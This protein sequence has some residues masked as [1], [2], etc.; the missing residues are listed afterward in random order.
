M[1]KGNTRPAENKELKLI[2]Q[3]A[4]GCIFHPGI[5]CRGKKENVRYITKIQKN[6]ENMKREVDMAKWITRL[7]RYTRFFSPIIKQCP[8]KITKKMQPSIQ[9]CNVFANMSSSEINQFQYVSNKVRYV[10]KS[11]LRDHIQ[12][13]PDWVHA[14]NAILETHAYLLKAYTLLANRDVVHMD[15]KPNNIMFD[16]AN[17]RPVVI[18]FGIS[19]H[20][21]S[22]KTPDDYSDAFFV[23]DSYY[24]WSIEIMVCNYMFSELGLLAAKTKMVTESDLEWIMDVFFKGYKGDETN[25]TFYETVLAKSMG[26]NEYADKYRVKC[27]DFFKQYVGKTWWDVY[28][29]FIEKQYYKTWDNYGLAV[30]Y[31]TMLN[32][33]PVEWKNEIMRNAIMREY[34][35]LLESI[36]TASPNERPT[37]NHVSGELDRV[38]SMA[39]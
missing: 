25:D 28:T 34:I 32:H 19:V 24:V 23:F 39:K 36:I 17:D 21:P 10:G 16:D 13:Q 31:L 20:I 5:N 1:S 35:R 22:L 4:Y 3:G 15:V 6:T 2:N 38:L 9:Q 26:E 7:P 12:Q 8:V 11:D 33:I 30:V 29:I 18:D 14:A 37:L 27:M